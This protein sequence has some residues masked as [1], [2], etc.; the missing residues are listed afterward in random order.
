M[1]KKIFYSIFIIGTVL[2]TI[3]KTHVN[4]NKNSAL[5]LANIEALADNTEATTGLT[6]LGLLGW[7]SYNCTKCGTGWN[8][9]GSTMIGT[10]KCST[11]TTK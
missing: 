2:F 7:C 5:S 4:N 9:L 8:A 1:K 10:H 3:T 6:C 11:S